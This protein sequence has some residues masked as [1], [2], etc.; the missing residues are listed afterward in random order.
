MQKGIAALKINPL[1]IAAYL[2]TQNFYG[3]GLK[4]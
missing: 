1:K 2:A 3:L 4:S